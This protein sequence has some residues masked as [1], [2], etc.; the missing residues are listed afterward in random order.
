MAHILLRANR[1]LDINS[2]CEPVALRQKY[3]S[4]GEQ[5][6]KIVFRE[7]QFNIVSS[8]AVTSPCS[9]YVGCSPRTDA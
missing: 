6:V 2:S 5:R 1:E 8:I 3:F 7:P 9:L 4:D